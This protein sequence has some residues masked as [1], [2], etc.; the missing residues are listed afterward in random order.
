MSNAKTILVTVI[1]AMTLS[2][3][4]VVQAQPPEGPPGGGANLQAQVNALKAQVAALETLTSS[5]SA[6]ATNVF[7]DGVNVHVRNGQG[8]TLTTNAVG[9]LIIGYNEDADL[10]L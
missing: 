8:S 3:L 5:M 10:M 9:N 7:F 2:V 4:L 6:D 1:F